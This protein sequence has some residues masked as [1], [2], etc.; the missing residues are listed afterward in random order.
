MKRRDFL[1]GT[2]KTGVAIGT[3]AAL[4]GPAL[5]AFAK[6]KQEEDQKPFSPRKAR[7]LTNR[8][9]LRPMRLL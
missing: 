9:I 3:A 1:K 8:K 2:L 7:R 5:K 4:G 6:G